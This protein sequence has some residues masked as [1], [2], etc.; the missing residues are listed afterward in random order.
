MRN[1][2]LAVAALGLALV[3]LLA[4][5]GGGANYG[6]V[7]FVDSDHGWVTGWDASKKATVISSTTDGGATWNI[8]GSKSFAGAKVTIHVVGPT[9]F[10]TA[11]T[12]VWCTFN[13]RAWYTTDG[14][15]TWAR[16]NVTMLP[17]EHFTAMSFANATVGW[18]VGSGGAIYRTADAGASYAMQRKAKVG[19]AFFDVVA[20][21][22]SICYALK[23]GLR[24]GVWTTL[25]GGVSWTRYRLPGKAVHP[26]YFAIDFP[27]DLI[28]YAVGSGGKIA[29]TTDG[30]VTWAAL[31][32][33][34]RAPL[35]GV[36]FVNADSGFAVGKGGTILHTTDGGATWI[37]QTS[38]TDVMLNSVDFV[39]GEEGWIVGQPGWAP[40]QEG[41]LLH[42]TD[43]GLTWE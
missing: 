9:T 5:C 27:T 42:T 18:A 39:S 23:D 33:G 40:G 22:E 28:G 12:G 31:V 3:A 7:S 19:G 32:S 36:C 34:K 1:K 26:V 41:V 8:V 11:T 6:T 30:G 43:A 38:G 20:R 24:C 15:S 35:H 10:S 4:A 14:G 37:A 2:T 21:S 25:D 13:D 29:K 17:N 16:S